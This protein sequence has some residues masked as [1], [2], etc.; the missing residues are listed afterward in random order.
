M[1]APQY[2]YLLS[3]LGFPLRRKGLCSKVESVFP[4]AFENQ[5]INLVGDNDQVTEYLQ[6]QTPTCTQH[7][8]GVVNPFMVICK[9]E[10]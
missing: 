7:D 1:R 4:S 6:K 8:K 3:M 2:L 9:S 10:I 5:C